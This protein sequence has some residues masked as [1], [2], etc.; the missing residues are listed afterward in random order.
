M[1]WP[2][3][4]AAM[5]SAAA[6]AAFLAWCAAYDGE[7]TAP[8]RDL[9]GWIRH[10]VHFGMFVGLGGG[11]DV[12]GWTDIPVAALLPGDLV[13]CRAPDSVHG[14]WSHVTIHLGGGEVAWH[15]LL[16]GTGGGAD[17]RELGWYARIRVLRPP[18][19]DA[20]RA[21]AV[22]A[23]RA[24]LGQPFV[25][26]AHP[27]DPRQGTCAALVADAWR[28]AGVIVDDGRT[29]TTPDAIAAAGLP[30][31]LDLARPESP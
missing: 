20:R 25:L 13:L 4:P 18:A 24:R 28:R 21:A 14:T 6:L 17:V 3:R 8:P 5:L 23:A 22:A 1:A 31:V 27:R 2:V 7:R 16:R 29:W 15:D 10:F 11:R 30:A 12:P 9:V 19:D 26:L